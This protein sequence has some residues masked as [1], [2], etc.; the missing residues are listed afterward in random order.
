MKLRL[1]NRL[2]AAVMAAVAAVVYATLGTATIGAAAQATEETG[3]T[4]HVYILTGQS[5]SLG[6][7]K[8]D[9]ASA[10]TLA[11]Y[12][13]AGKNGDADGILMWDGNMGGS[14]SAAKSD[15][16][17]WSN[18]GKAWMTVQPQQA[19]AGSGTHGTAGTPYENMTGLGDS[20]SSWEANQGHGVMG[21]EYGFAYMMQKKGWDTSAAKDDIAIIKVSRDGGANTNWDKPAEGVVNCY[22]L[23]LDSVMEALRNADKTTYTTI[24]LDGLMY[25]QGESNGTATGADTKF[26][27]F[28]NNLKADILARVSADD[29][30]KDIVQIGK[31]GESANFYMTVGEPASWGNQAN[32]TP[33]ATASTMK[34]LA[35]G[36]E[37]ASFV[38]TRDLDKITSGDSYGVHY[39]GNS[40][41]TIGARY[42]YAMAAE[43]G[44][45]VTEGG[46]SR[47]RSQE[48]GDTFSAADRTATDKN[49]RTPL[50]LNEAAAWWRS[51]GEA[52]T[53]T[54]ADLADK[55]AVWDVS[56]A[57]MLNTTQGAETLSANLAVGGI[58]IEDPYAE[59]DSTGTH[60]ATITIKNAE[61]ANAIL[62]VG[63]KG[64]ELQRGNLSL[65]TKVAT[66]GAQTWTVAGGKKLTIGNAVSGTDTVTLHKHADIASS[67][68]AQFDF[69]AATDAGHRTWSIGDGV[70][71]ALS[72]TG[73]A[74]ST[75]AVEAAA[76][77]A[78]TGGQVSLGS[79]TLGNGA[80]LD[81]T[82]GLTLTAGTVSFG[83]TAALTF[84]YSNGS[85]SSL[86]AGSISA[87][88]N[89]AVTINLG[90]A[91]GLSRAEFTL[92]TGWSGWSVSDTAGSGKVLTLGSTAPDGYHL[93][94][95]SAGALVLSGMPVYPDVQKTWVSAP[96]G[97]T[98]TAVSGL[99]AVN[100]AQLVEGSTTDK[101]VLV[102]GAGN[103]SWHLYG[104]YMSSMEGGA[105]YTEMQVDRANFI[106][107]IGTFNYNTSRNT[108][109]TGDYNLKIAAGTSI[110][111]VFG[112][113]DI[114]VDGNVYTEL[115]AD[116]TYTNATYGLVGVFCADVTGD[117]SLVINKGTFNSGVNIKGIQGNNGYTGSI[118]GT[119]SIEVNG[120]NL[121]NIYV[122]DA[123]AHTIKSAQVILNGGTVNG[124][125]YGSNTGVTI[126]NGT[127]IYIGGE[128]IVKG[129]IFGG[130]SNA[131]AG[132]VTLHDMA[133]NAKFLTNFG[134]GKSIY[135]DK[136]VLN[137]TTIGSGFNGTLYANTVTIGEGSSL[138]AGKLA[139]GAALAGAGDYKLATGTQAMTS[140]VTLADDWA[141]T[142]VLSGTI[143]NLNLNKSNTTAQGLYKAGSTIRLNGV[144]GHFANANQQIAA[145][146][147]IGEGG[148]AI[149]NGWSANK[150]TFEGKLIGEGDFTRA[151]NGS[152]SS[153]LK[154]QFEF[155]GDVSGYTGTFVN[156]EYSTGATTQ[157][158]S[159]TLEF[160]GKA[161][162]INASIKN[163]DQAVLA[164]EVTFKAAATT[165]N[166]TI[167][168]NPAITGNKI[169]LTLANTASSLTINNTAT[170]TSLSAAGKTVIIGSN[171]EGDSATHGALTVNGAA[172]IGT[173][174]VKA[175]ATSTF[176]GSGTVGTLK[177]EQGSATTLTNITVGSTGDRT[178]K[179]NLT[180]GNG[181]TLNITGTDS[182]G[183]NSTNTV[184]VEKGGTLD[185]GT[186]RW[187]LKANNSLVLNGG[188]IQGAGDGNNGA[189]DFMDAGNIVRATDDSEISASIRLRNAAVTFDTAAGK[190][191]T[192]SGK[193]MNNAL[194]KSGDGTLLMKAAV[195]NTY[196]SGTTVNAGTLKVE[197]TAEEALGT[198]S[199]TVA[200][201]A[202][203]EVAG[204]L[205]IKGN[206]ATSLSNAGTLKLDDGAALTMHATE[207]GRTHNVGTVQLEGAS[208]SL[209][210]RWHAATQNIAA[211]NGA[212]D[213][214]LSLISNHCTQT[215][216]WNIGTVGGTS[217][218]NGKLVLVNSDTDAPSAKNRTAT[219]NFVQGNML[220]G[221]TLEL[222]NG[223]YT[224]GGMGATMTNNV[225][226][227][228]DSVSF[229]GI[230]DAEAAS[231]PT[232]TVVWNLSKDASV[233]GHATLKLDGSGTYSTAA[234]VGSDIDIDKSGSGTQS[235]SGDM[236]H[237][238]GYVTAT[239]GTLQLLNQTSVN[240]T[241]LTLQGTA[242]HATTVGIYQGGSAASAE[243]GITVSGVLT[244]N[245]HATLH[246]DLTLVNGATLAVSGENGLHMG[247]SL[248]LAQDAV[249]NLSDEL[250]V[251]LNDMVCGDSLVLF[252]G[253]D[254]FNLN[255]GA[256]DADATYSA[257]DYFN[258]T[259]VAYG[260]HFVVRYEIPAGS[261]D[262]GTVSLYMATPEPA[263]TTLSLLALAGLMARRRR[264]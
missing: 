194:V 32:S 263:T 74:Q 57:N 128:A 37:Q 103:S 65:Q 104:G 157:T 96:A 64:I 208:A 75:L 85:F 27:T 134:S 163:T 87:G 248:T 113:S 141:G 78:L 123:M 227:K 86:Q 97:A 228:A 44:I 212:A 24:E 153:K 255:G 232:R 192:L 177:S 116:A 60:N 45:D 196:S 11:Y 264:H 260:D 91:T 49:A 147:D 92:G 244:A 164:T 126:T 151:S 63:N 129:D 79:L 38:Y 146:I 207:A 34:T 83:D 220:S 1:P 9:P 71:V 249:I 216:T 222:K 234:T 132:E 149:N 2:K 199:V 206:T 3:K 130:V 210:N 189:L 33:N 39:D 77:A 31:G 50:S 230:T 22:T 257:R 247:S 197:S 15:S 171:G 253:V 135:A 159:L 89:S 111:A 138:V 217:A 252:S 179:G 215:G 201:G 200:S 29:S 162:L 52:A 70:S 43:Q 156:D 154:A 203:L 176:N 239:A 58:R 229:G 219:F 187:T 168:Y 67:A 175:G 59:D 30:L 143:S 118:G 226:L 16:L 48:Y 165:L 35:D 145:D 184:T 94:V 125:V 144:T 127:S 137:D 40:E 14:L 98:A 8:G 124:N 7:V 42:A 172:D 182:L 46:T 258:L 204:A 110:A 51:A 161:D 36:S 158:A 115:N 6:A 20:R 105:L 101:A 133:E 131:K 254:A 81:L 221:A 84:N 69:S 121:Q 72:G 99:Q 235:F 54:V 251:I 191:L 73:F 56:S 160:G 136:L 68:A 245:E 174:E 4:L 5:N 224:N 155:T 240:V 82:G 90:N 66:N 214:E 198:G 26:T 166:G 225:V 256:Y 18:E 114:K 167:S 100:S 213:S 193:I 218:Y 152:S 262:G 95:N 170:I 237:F 10:D 246:A 140:G 190:T 19:P 259:G 80:S 76:S 169:N 28:V 183:Y 243:G 62:T 25:L 47:V 242:E 120:G 88:D 180:I 231:A 185:F 261:V 142:V 61:G 211:I 250:T 93:S 17:A 238:N 108:T 55:V 109:V 181:A 186:G 13:T 41:I 148:L 53:W 195:N 205:T 106:S 178:L 150:Q 119:L 117:V 223:T 139:A 209:M 233:S 12:S 241:D 202:T 173:L 21:P 188:T 107:N 236:S 112:A 102:S 122:S 23:L